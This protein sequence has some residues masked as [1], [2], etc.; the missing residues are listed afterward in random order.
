[1]EYIGIVEENDWEGE[2]FG[3]YFED[4]PDTREYLE[5][6]QELLP[7]DSPYQVVLEP[8]DYE[9]L[10]HMHKYDQNTYKSRVNVYDAND[11]PWEEILAADFEEDD[12]LYK[13]NCFTDE[14]D[15]FEDVDDQSEYEYED[16]DEDW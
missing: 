11:Q 2:E 5:R 1:M 6:I 3:Y 4:D 15:I 16:E 12:P 10:A 7:E 14:L 13:G 8:I 9:T